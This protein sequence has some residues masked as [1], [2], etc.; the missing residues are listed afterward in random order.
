MGLRQGSG[1]VALA[2]LLAGC[3]ATT[4]K[5]SGQWGRH[6]T[7]GG[8]GKALTATRGQPDEAVAWGWAVALPHDATRA[9]LVRPVVQREALAGIVPGLGKGEIVQVASASLAP[10]LEVVAVGKQSIADYGQLNAAVEAAATAGKSVNVTFRDP[11]R[12]GHQPSAEI[13]PAVLA[14]LCHEATPDKGIV[15]VT[16]D[17]NP[18]AVVRQGSIRCKAM[19]RVE[20]DHGLLH[21]ALS[22]SH[23][24]GAAVTLP[25]EVQATCD[26]RP[27]YCLTVADTLERLYGQPTQEH[28]PAAASFAAVSER[29]GYLIPS[30]FKRLEKAGPTA[31]RHA[32]A[33]PAFAAL[34]GVAYPGSPLLGDARALAGFLLQRQILQPGEPARLGWIVFADDSLGKG[35]SVQLAIDLGQGPININFELLAP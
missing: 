2:L 14:A 6:T 21:V 10:P 28:D 22:L 16:E 9:E 1:F 15:R 5:S 34:P 27:L 26:G 33:Q 30:N 7:N 4:T 29:E 25:A 11:A 32:P 24:G 20:R 13:K 12:S 35:K 23:I 18:W 19:A 17:G 3:T 31:G 8:T